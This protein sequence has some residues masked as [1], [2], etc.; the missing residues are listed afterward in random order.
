[1]SAADERRG[2]GTIAEFWHILP[3]LLM[4]LH[5]LLHNLPMEPELVL[6]LEL[7]VELMH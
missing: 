4:I 1:M 5:H 2:R 7:V 6:E 3:R